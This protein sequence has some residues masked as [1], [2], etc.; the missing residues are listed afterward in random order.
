MTLAKENFALN[1]T[2]LTNIVFSFFPFSFILGNLIVN[3]NFLLFCCLGIFHLRSKILTNK[4]N[5]PLK[6]ISLFFLLVLFST[7][8]NF[9]ESLYFGESDKFDLSRLIKSILFLRFF[10]IL[11]LVFLLSKF[12]I[13][14][15]KLFFTSAAIL[16]VLISID[17]IFQY[18]FG[19]N[20]IGIKNLP[21]HNPSFF[22]DE[23][24]SG[25][26]IQNFCFFSILFLTNKIR[27]K[28]NLFKIF[29]TTF[30]ICIL[31][32]GILLSGNR[33]PFLLF[34]FGLFLLFFFVKDLKKI[35]LISFCVLPIIFGSLIK[36]DENLKN[37]QSN[38][39]K[40]SKRTIVYV[41]KT[42][43]N[44]LFST[45]QNQK[46][47]EKK[48]KMKSKSSFSS[49][50]NDD[51]EEDAYQKMAFTAFETWKKNKVFGNG[52]KSFRVECRKILIEQKKG[53]CSN[54]P[55]NYYLEILADLGIIGLFLV[56]GIAYIFMIFLIRNYKVLKKENNL[57]NLF[58]LAAIIS[59]FLEVFPFKSSGSVFSTNNTTYMVLMGSIILS[60]KKLLDGKNF[61]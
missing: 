19:F 28:N 37:A 40:Y 3:L 32:I 44:N 18:I 9:I 10:I 12:E 15:Y 31:A 38:F 55:H 61:R 41:S 50:L 45:A 57:E 49:S 33:M 7:S 53:L 36:V 23:L 42:L 43:K 46:E 1:S 35:L 47:I 25:G 52:I 58:L 34:I 6:I 4:L 56:M 13:I 22:G 39:Y 30:T 17:V 24:I 16:P 51:P 60:Y 54:H 26:Y 11:L 27:N 2:S 29:L 5:F 14:N 48:E 59:L 8:L 21:R 20:V